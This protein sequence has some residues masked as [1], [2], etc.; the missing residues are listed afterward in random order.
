VFHFFVLSP[1]TSQLH[2]TP[3][4]SLVLLSSSP[5]ADA[6]GVLNNANS[7]IALRLTTYDDSLVT[8]YPPPFL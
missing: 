5:D 4:H 8:F 7:L 6:A 2:S 3:G 1:A